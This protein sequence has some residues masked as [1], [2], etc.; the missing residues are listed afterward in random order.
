MPTG[1]GGERG[2]MR[3]HVLITGATGFVGSALARVLARE[4]PDAEVTLADRRAGVPDVRQVEMADPEAV[5]AL[6]GECQPS[7]VFH[8]AGATRAPSL[9]AFLDANLEPTRV[10]LEAIEQHAPGAR[11]MVPGSAAEYG[12]VAAVDLPIRE[13]QALRPISAYGVSK[14]CQC[15]LTP[16][17]AARGLS[18]MTGRAFNVVGRGIPDT[19]FLG[20]V[21]RQLKDVRDGRADHIEVGELGGMRDLTDIDDICRAM[22]DVASL[23]VPGEA[24]NICSGVGVSMADVLDRLMTIAGLRVDVRRVGERLRQGDIA[25]SVGSSEKLRRLSGW[26]PRTG[27]DESLRALVDEVLGA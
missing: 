16:H 15:L 10:L 23:G 5:G 18:V 24:Y 26:E 27:L 1:P 12:D 2:T 25:D 4:W 7:H 17:Y 13:T 9:K 6:I 8:L 21:V 22:L 3:G 19:L 20:A 11:V 14:A